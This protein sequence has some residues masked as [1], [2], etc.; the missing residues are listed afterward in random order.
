MNLI[1]KFSK[2]CLLLVFATLSFVFVGNVA[3]AA[4]P[5]PSNVL[6][7]AGDFDQGNQVDLIVAEYGDGYVLRAPQ[8]TVRLYTS[9]ANPTINII[10]AGHCIGPGLP[11]RGGD[12]SQ[13]ETIFKVY[14]LAPD[15]STPAYNNTPFQART[16][17]SYTASSRDVACGQTLSIRVSGNPNTN[18]PSQYSPAT[19]QWAFEIEADMTGPPGWNMFKYQV[20]AGRFSYYAGSGDHFG[21]KDSGSGIP[22]EPGDFHL[23]F[24]PGCALKEGDTA[25]VPL[26]WFDADAG[27]ANQG[28]ESPVKTVL[29]EYNEQNQLDNTQPID[30]ISGDDVGDS[31]TVTVKGHHKYEWVWQHIYSANGIQFQLPFDSYNTMIDFTSGGDCK[32]TPPP[33]QLAACQ[34]VSYSPNWTVPTGT[35]IT[36]TAKIK[37][38]GNV[39]WDKGY[40]LRQI[41]PS[42]ANKSYIESGPI[43]PGQTATFQFPVTRDTPQSVDF[44]YEMVNP[45][46]DLFQPIC[47]GANGAS[48]FPGYHTLQWTDNGGGNVPNGIITS[49]CGQIVVRATSN[50][51][52]TEQTGTNNVFDNK[53]NIIR[54]DP[55]YSEIANDWVDLQLVFTNVDNP[56]DSRT[57]NM[58]MQPRTVTLTYDT[59]NSFDWLRPHN[60]YTLTLNVITQGSYGLNNSYPPYDFTQTKK[61]GEQGENRPVCMSARCTARAVTNPTKPEQNEPVQITYG[62]ILTN[63]TNKTFTGEYDV[64]VSSVP[65]ASMSPSSYDIFGPGA[66][67]S[68]RNFSP[69]ESRFV[70]PMTVTV[71]AYAALNAYLYFN[72]TNI[73][74]KVRDPG[75]NF[76]PCGYT[77]AT[78]P[79][80]PPGVCCPPNVVCTTPICTAGCCPGSPCPSPSPNPN[81]IPPDP[82]C[83]GPGTI[84]NIP[85]F[86]ADSRPYLKVYNGD[87]SAGGM[88]SKGNGATCVA[89]DLDFTAPDGNDSS[90]DNLL[91][92][93]IATYSYPDSGYMGSPKGSSVDFGAFALGLV[94]GTP[95]NDLAYGFY[96]NAK[97]AG[98]FPTFYDDL[99]FANYDQL[100]GL[101]GGSSPDGSSHCATNYFTDA[102][103]EQNASFGPPPASPLSLTGMENQQYYQAPQVVISGGTIAAGKKLTVFV[104]GDVYIK[105]NITYG[106]WT[107]NPTTNDTPY[108]A[109]IVQGNIHID[110]GVGLLDGFYVAQPLAND[111]KGVFST[112]SPSGAFPDATAVSNTCHTKLVVNGAVSAEHVYLLRSFGSLVDAANNEPFGSGTQAAEVFNYA[113]SMLIGQPIFKSSDNGAI[114]PGTVQGLFS[115]PPVF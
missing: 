66:N 51:T 18:V 32:D 20:S 115:L 3:H 35:T 89:T 71:R 79:P 102:N 45:S 69:G 53:G 91:Q 37:N 27:V 47:G 93:G 12:N 22:G 95:R 58:R 88:F 25:R 30:I 112:C 33:P 48:G 55:I 31:T 60:S 105:G 82:F 65:P 7:K 2:A 100:G 19:G 109:L 64:K 98:N 1:N 9:N 34:T 49:T 113:P 92:G 56:S 94:H 87:V 77:N 97:N 62:M 75:S 61:I 67:N 80:C 84:P 70:G 108:F 24:A 106:N 101:I 42:G 81:C 29:Y 11:D 50:A 103:L 99:N 83:N 114:L 38:T 90:L 21:L 68:N 52:H 73:D 86:S 28:G 107:L 110:P 40:Q 16:P 78:T 14:P 13:A 54:K 8:S 26:K 4:A 6:P 46:G 23:G 74:P 39:A 59:F 43:N 104:K 72:G 57:L 76:P 10:D 96:G 85:S 111:T 41:D 5:I 36:V 17:L 44:S 63:D 15:N